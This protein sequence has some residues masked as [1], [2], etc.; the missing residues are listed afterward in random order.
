M[1]YPDNM[2]W[3]RYDQ[4]IGST[5]SEIDQAKRDAMENQ[6]MIMTYLKQLKTSVEALN[7][8]IEPI[9]DFEHWLEDQDYEPA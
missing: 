7:G 6:K 9:E 2:N 8:Q 3:A 4:T 1:N 5:L